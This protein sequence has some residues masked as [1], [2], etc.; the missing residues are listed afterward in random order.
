MWDGCSVNFINGTCLKKKNQN[1]NKTINFKEKKK[2]TSRNCYL[3]S[4]FCG[5]P[6]LLPTFQKILFELNPNPTRTRFANKTISVKSGYLTQFKT[7]IH[8]I[9][10]SY[11]C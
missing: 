5:K 2:S 7:L 9:F 3:D 11:C 4:C 8:I 10:K 1:K 6:L